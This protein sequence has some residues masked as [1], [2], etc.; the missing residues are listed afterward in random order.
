MPVVLTSQPRRRWKPRALVVAATLAGGH[1]AWASTLVD[2]MG[3]PM[4]ALGTAL[5]TAASGDTLAISGTCQQDVTITV[6]GLTLTVKTGDSPQSDGIEG[7]VEV[8]GARNVALVDLLLGNS[9]SFSFASGSD[10]AILYVHDGATVVLN[11]STISN[12]PLLGIL[13]ERSAEVSLLDTT[14]IS[15][16]QSL[17]GDTTASPNGFGISARDHSSLFF[18]TVSSGVFVEL[19]QGGGVALIDGSSLNATKADGSSIDSNGGQQIL[20]K[21]DSSVHATNLSIDG[22]SCSFNPSVCGDGIDAF[23]SSNVRVDGSSSVIE[24]VQNRNA[25]LVQ[26]GST[27]LI[28]GVTLFAPAGSAQVVQA[29]DNSVIALAGGNMV[30]SGACTG[31]TTGV[32]VVIDHV[33]TLIDVPPAEFGYPVAADAIFGSG[34]AQLQ[35]TIDLGQGLVSG[36]PSLTWNTGGASIAV[37]QN[38]SFRLQGGVSITGA[39][40]LAQA[41]NGFFNTTA[42]GTNTVSVGVSCPFNA[43]PNAHVV[44]GT[45]SPP[46]PMAV[47]FSSASNPQCLPF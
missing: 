47:S 11:T 45:L 36:S 12:S 16:G 46:P 32:A 9:L 34:E 3:S 19:N 27:L 17:S 14:V 29:S 25:V 4:T 38:S 31:S 23:S 40:A 33:S 18:K 6:P 24:A 44:P 30:C 22:S 42:G 2:C 1:Q 5:S 7:Q 15:S 41:S 37:A 13:A 10:Q 43:I 21:G 35:S 28:S 39:V 26:G 20:L 8:A